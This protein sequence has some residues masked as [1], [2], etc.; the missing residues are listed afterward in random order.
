MGKGGGGSSKLTVLETA[1]G[2]SGSKPLWR[3][4]GMGGTSGGGGEGG[5]LWLAGGRE[6]QALAGWLWW[7]RLCR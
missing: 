5:G 2:R 6:P 4:S 1:P 3:S 7:G